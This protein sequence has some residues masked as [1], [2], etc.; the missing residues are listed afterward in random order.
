MRSLQSDLAPNPDESLAQYL[1]R[2][3]QVCGLSQKEVVAKAGIHLQSLGKI[4]R[5]KTV[6]LNQKTRSGLAYA[7]NIPVEYLEAVGR[8]GAVEAAS[9]LKFCPH[10]WVPGTSPEPMWLDLRSKHCFLCGTV[11]R[12]RCISCNEPITSLQHRFC[13]YCGTT[14]KV[15]KS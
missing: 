8:G 9:A 3:R 14:Y 13:P 10:C 11:L 4:E 12:N 2:L 15:E 7:L 1:R 6:K 5:G